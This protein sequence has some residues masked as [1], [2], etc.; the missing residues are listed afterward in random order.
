[1]GRIVRDLICSSIIVSTD[2]N[3]QQQIQFGSKIER[4]N[5][6]E[7]KEEILGTFHDK[8]PDCAGN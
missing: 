7:N 8:Q 6:L 3:T 1:M 5:R 2:F 4:K